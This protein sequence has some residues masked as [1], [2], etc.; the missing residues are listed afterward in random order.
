MPPELVAAA[1]ASTTVQSVGSVPAPPPPGQV[2]LGPAS[3]APPT[4]A[5]TSQPLPKMGQR[6]G[7]ASNARN[8]IV[9]IN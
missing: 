5:I 2:M 7:A 1:A 4:G 9:S 8:A 6:E 3:N